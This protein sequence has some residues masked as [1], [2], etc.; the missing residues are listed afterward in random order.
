MGI[1]SFFKVQKHKQFDYKPLYYDKRK[2]EL[3]QIKQ[4]YNVEITENG[5]SEYRPNLK[6]KIRSHYE[7]SSRPAPR[8]SST[9]LIVFIIIL[10]FI[11]Y[12]LFY[13]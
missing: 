8:T 10:I 5:S 7:K 4:K 6:G 11:G 9:R 3:E 13:K 12:Y 2:E 1:S